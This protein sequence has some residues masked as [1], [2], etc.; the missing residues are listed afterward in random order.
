MK[1]YVFGVDLGGTTCKMGLFTTKGDLLDKW[2][3]KTDT[4]NGGENILKDIAGA[5]HGKMVE[6]GLKLG[7]VEGVGIGVPG[8]VMKDGT[9]NR[10]VNLG[11]GVTPVGKDLAALVGLPVKVG[12][13]ANVAALGEA[14]VGAGKNF[15]SIVM[16]TLGTGIGGGVIIDNKILCGATGAGGEIGHF[17]VNPNEL[18]ACGCGRYGCIEQYASA[19]GI[20]RMARKR[21]ST[22]PEDSLLKEIELDSITAKDVFDAVKKGDHLASEVAED[23]CEMLADVLSKVSVV[24]NPDAFVI[25]GGVSKAG[26][27]LVDMLTEPFMRNVFHA[28]ADTKILLATLGNDAGIYGAARQVIEED[29]I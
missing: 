11:W 22:S 24:V 23:V 28:C 14:W 25:G 5:V 29:K 4:S 1:K 16:V 13:D 26:Q 27:V 10:C 6:K 7:D 21:V 18:E 3:I 9:V 8:P 12:N 17:I 19:T 2:E 20:A 15:D